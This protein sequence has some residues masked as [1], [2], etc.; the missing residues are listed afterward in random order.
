MLQAI[1]SFPNFTSKQSLP[2]SINN[3]QNIFLSSHYKI[4]FYIHNAVALS[5]KSWTLVLYVICAW[6]KQSPSLSSSNLMLMGRTCLC[7]CVWV[8][9]CIQ[10]RKSTSS[11]TLPSFLGG[12][13]GQTLRHKLGH[14]WHL[15]MCLYTPAC[16]SL[17]CMCVTLG[18]VLRPSCS[19]YHFHS[20]SDNCGSDLA[21]SLSKN[22][23]FK[24]IE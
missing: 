5:T 6:Q 4:L 15:V 22:S 13:K 2:A 8:G 17:M 18:C 3:I 19:V 1:P 12:I 24:N 10:I 20:V 21:L 23:P 14:A 11:T 7:V 16:L 9:E